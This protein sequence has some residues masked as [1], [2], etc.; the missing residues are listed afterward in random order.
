MRLGHPS[1]NCRIF[2]SSKVSSKKKLVFPFEK[3]RY[4]Y[5]TRWRKKNLNHSMWPSHFHLS[6][7]TWSSIFVYTIIPKNY[8]PTW[9][10]RSK[11]STDTNGTYLKRIKNNQ[12]VFVGDL[13]SWMKYFFVI[14][15]KIVTSFMKKFC[16]FSYF[17]FV[18]YLFNIG[19]RHT[20]VT[21]SI[22]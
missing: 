11:T 3:Y 15:D 13:L 6:I 17:I 19:N 18:F 7:P 21:M 10:L 12:N 20:M 22:R 2:V 9:S 14:K 5:K 16:V 4:I 1:I 8:F